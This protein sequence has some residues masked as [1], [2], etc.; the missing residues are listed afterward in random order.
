MSNF[1]STPKARSYGYKPMFYT[2]DK[3][4]Q[5]KRERR[6]RQIDRA[7]EREAAARERGEEPEDEFSYIK[8]ARKERKKSNLRV[9]LILLVLLIFFY[10]FLQSK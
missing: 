4:L 8:F 10:F 5:E 6:F 9:F 2:K 3:E 1:F 7:L